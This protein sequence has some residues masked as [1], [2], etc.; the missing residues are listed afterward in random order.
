MGCGQKEIYIC[1]YVKHSLFLYSYLL[2]IVLFICITTVNLLM[3][4]LVFSF[5]GYPFLHWSPVPDTCLCFSSYCP[6]RHYHTCKFLCIGA[7]I[8]F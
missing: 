3:P 8:V 6:I 4:T 5:R 2:I 7:E 1:E